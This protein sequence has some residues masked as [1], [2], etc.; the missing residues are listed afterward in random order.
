MTDAVSTGVYVEVF[1]EP[2]APARAT[3]LSL[4]VWATNTPKQGV[5]NKTLAPVSASGSGT[6][7]RLGELS[8]TLGDVTAFAEGRVGPFYLG[9]ADITLDS[10]SLDASGT[11]TR[12]G[13]ATVLLDALTVSANGLVGG[14]SSSALLIGA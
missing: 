9:V 8:Q 5:L 7:T 10:V 6:V 1:V 11:V 2:N 12:L 4:E 3:Q 14:L 13:E